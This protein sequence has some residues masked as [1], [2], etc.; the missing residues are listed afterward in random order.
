MGMQECIEHLL[1]IED[2]PEP[3]LKYI[4]DGNGRN[5]VDD[6]D[7][8]FGETWINAPLYPDP[9]EVPDPQQQARILGYRRVS[10][11]AW[12]FLQY[13]LSLIHI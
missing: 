1:K 7:V 6:P 2:L 10:M 13:H 12:S 8:K 11:V 3:P 9:E 5:Q 4:P